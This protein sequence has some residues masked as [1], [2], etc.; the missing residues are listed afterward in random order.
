[1]TNF[2]NVVRGLLTIKFEKKKNIRQYKQNLAIVDIWHA[3]LL[4][5]IHLQV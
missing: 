5:I 4:K 2:I 1:M 3:Y